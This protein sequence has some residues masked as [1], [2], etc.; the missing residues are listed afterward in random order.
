MDCWWKNIERAEFQLIHVQF[1][2]LQH[3][4]RSNLGPGAIARS[5]PFRTVISYMHGEHNSTTCTEK[6]STTA[7]F[8]VGLNCILLHPLGQ[9]NCFFSTWH[10]LAIIHGRRIKKRIFWPGFRSVL[11]T[12]PRKGLQ[13]LVIGRES[14]MSL[15]PAADGSWC[16]RIRVGWCSKPGEHG[17]AQRGKC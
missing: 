14:W 16:F 7:L 6:T 4:F 2:W 5:L 1:L 9:R 11:L 13:Y 10:D 8:I 15:S 3:S 12:W 17:A